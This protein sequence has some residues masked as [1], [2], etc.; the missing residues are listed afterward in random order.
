[1]CL[2]K[3]QSWE[4]WG[5]REAFLPPWNQDCTDLAPSFPSQGIEQSPGCFLTC[6]Q[7]PFKFNRRLDSGE[8]QTTWF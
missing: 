6:F 7:L 8:T 1:M 2:L 5:P 4:S 3:P